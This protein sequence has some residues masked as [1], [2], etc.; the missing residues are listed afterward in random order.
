MQVEQGA[1]GTKPGSRVFGVGSPGIWGAGS[2]K[3]VAV[4]LLASWCYLSFSA[5]TL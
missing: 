5:S 3:H 1:L 2:W 4:S